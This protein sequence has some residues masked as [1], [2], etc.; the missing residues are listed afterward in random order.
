MIL[1]AGLAIG[2]GI[3]SWNSTSVLGD[4]LPM[5]FGVG[6]AVVLSG[7]MEPTLKTNDL[8]IV[9]HR[10]SYEVDDVVVYED[11]QS[12]VIHR[13]IETDGSSVITQGDANN[14]PDEAID[15][16]QIKGAMLF[17]IPFVGNIFKFI[18]SL[19]GTIMIVALAVYLLYRSRVKEQEKDQKELLAIAEEI[20]Q[21]RLKK[22]SA[23]ERPAEDTY[24]GAPE[25][26]MS[27]STDPHDSD[28][29]E[30]A[31]DADEAEESVE[32]VEA[33]APVQ[34]AADETETEPIDEIPVEDISDVDAIDNI[35]A[36]NKAVSAHESD[37][38]VI[39]EILS[40]NSEQ[41]S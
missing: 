9:T 12:L 35:V 13:I 1:V 27:P 2:L 22:Q 19:P 15:E 4:Q 26:E 30:D 32:A 23:P 3:F 21:L 17:R 14:I 38:D 10:D 25:D 24:P 16:S 29:T 7:S 6:A 28:D 41:S 34:S 18:K 31:E 5:P 33:D 8:V 11:N 40:F 37:N 39:D 20:R 36:F